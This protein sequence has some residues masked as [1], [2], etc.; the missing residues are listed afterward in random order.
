MQQL[1]TQSVLGTASFPG[2]SAWL[3][4]EATLDNTG[5]VL[6]PSQYVISISTSF[7]Q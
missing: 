3:G 1:P 4:N 5:Y 6:M 2:Y 7:K